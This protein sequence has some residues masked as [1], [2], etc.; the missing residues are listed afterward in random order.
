LGEVFLG[1]NYYLVTGGEKFP[2]IPCSADNR[3]LIFKLLKVNELKGLNR[4]KKGR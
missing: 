3:E 4:C 2:V 1:E